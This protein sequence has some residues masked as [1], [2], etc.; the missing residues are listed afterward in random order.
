MDAGR[1]DVYPYLLERRGMAFGDARALLVLA[2]KT[3]R[4]EALASPALGLRQP[5]LPCDYVRADTLVPDRSTSGL[6]SSVSLATAA[7]R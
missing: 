3:K 6:E 5:C 2:I 7:H 4:A 1:G